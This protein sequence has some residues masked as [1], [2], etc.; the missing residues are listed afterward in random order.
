MIPTQIWFFI[1]IIAAAQ[2]LFLGLV[3]LFNRNLNRLKRFYFAFLII[4]FSLWV[5]E[6][7]AYWSPYIMKYPHLMFLSKSLPWLFGPLLY[8]FARSFIHDNVKFKRIELLHFVPFII[9]FGLYMP[10]ILMTESEKIEILNRVVY[11]SLPN[12]SDK[13]YILIL[14]GVIQLIIYLVL[15]FNLLKKIQQSKRL[16]I[17][18][19]I[20]SLTLFAFVPMLHIVNVKYFDFH[21][22]AKF[23]SFILLIS[24]ILIYSLSY[25]LI[26]YP[27]KIMNKDAIKYA[28]NKLSINRINDIEQRVLDFILSKNNYRDSSLSLRSISVEIN[29]PTNYISQV[30]NTKFGFSVTDLV[31]KYRVEEVKERLFDKKYKHYSILA[32]A[33]DSGFSNKASFY[34]AFKKHVG[35]TP[36]EFKKSSKS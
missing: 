21:F 32:I 22:L 14:L 20:T 24:S 28:K 6:F 33:K 27:Q 11:T 13:Y 1:A 10:L 36:T 7:G 15:T 2:G 16:M 35:L 5:A 26:L 8:L 25:Y 19:M 4:G 30:I 31:N 23:G 29:V 18:I 9:R 17:K 12:Y 3:L 34:N